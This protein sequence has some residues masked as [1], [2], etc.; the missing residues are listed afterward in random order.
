MD[1]LQKS[2]NN[3]SYNNNNIKKNRT[4][5]SVINIKSKNN[6]HSNFVSLVNNLSSDIKLFY[7]STKLFL[8]QGKEPNNKRNISSKQIF[9]LIEQNL[10]DFISKAKEIFK[11]MKYIQ[12]INLI[13]QDMTHS[14]AS[15]QS[16]IRINPN[17]DNIYLNSN[18]EN[19]FN[20]S[21]IMNK[22]KLFD[23][24][25]YIPSFCEN[26][27]NN[28]NNTNNNNNNYFHKNNSD[29]EINNDNDMIKSLNNSSKDMKI[30]NKYNKYNKLIDIE[31]N[32]NRN[33]VNKIMYNNYNQYNN[34]KR[35]NNNKSV[36]N[37][38]KKI[39]FDKKQDNSS[40]GSLGVSSSKGIN[41]N[42]NTNINNSN[43]LN[44]NKLLIGNN[45]ILD[46]LNNLIA[47]MKELRLIKGNIFIK[48]LDAEKHKNLLNKIYNE[49]IIIIKIISKENNMKTLNNFLE[50]NKQK[51][52]SSNNLNFNNR[53]FNNNKNEN[54]IE[55]IRTDNYNKDINY[56]DLI[57]HQ[58]KQI[59]NINNDNKNFH[60]IKQQ[61][62]ELQKEKEKIIKINNELKQKIIN[63]E[64]IKNKHQ[65]MPKLLTQNF[66]FQFI[67]NEDY[68]GEKAQKILDELNGEIKE[69]NEKIE[70]INIEL[71]NYKEKDNKSNEEISKLNEEINKKK[72]EINKCQKEIENLINKNNE[73]INDNKQLKENLEIENKNIEKYKKIVS[74][75]EE[76]IKDL[77]NNSKINI[78]N[79]N[80]TI[81]EEPEKSNNKLP[82]N[83]S[84]NN[85]NINLDEKKNKKRNSSK[86]NE[87]QMEQDKIYLKYELLKNDYDK[88]NNTLQQ[89]QKL[90]DN[91]SKISSETASKT[92]IDE[93]ILELMAE[94]KKEIEDLK[95][96]YNKNII[97]LKMN[98]PS[99]FSPLTHKILI[100]KRYASYDLKWYLLTILTEEEKNYKNTFWVSDID[101]K[102]ILNQFDKFKTEREIEDE[103]FENLYKMQEKWIKQI[104]E[105]EKL[106]QTLK[107]KL[108]V[109]ENKSITE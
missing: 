84:N 73:Y 55:N 5:S 63:L 71:N 106:I 48:S 54:N 15:P 97:N 45:E 17:N 20:R 4:S 64:K 41:N 59:K 60:I 8:N 85:N 80:S 65:S 94:H 87:Y 2:N 66:Y 76:E 27:N 103:K 37:L 62:I 83:N 10:I 69:K 72:E 52:H 53:L 77:K 24:E 93:Q 75:Q 51:N 82:L 40:I 7:H 109:Y 33:S 90:L 21:Y 74:Y 78:I 3:I 12:K 107:D 104:D 56:R 100:D 98:Q 88:L 58:S 19:N 68:I 89:K 23:E 6:S 25:V 29:N 42:T 67:K 57:I 11:R 81:K 34:L 31:E 18:C 26:N 46:K 91:Y 101:M 99:P 44:Q 96:E 28:N 105:N 16:L 38:R 47:L 39:I 1:I 102:P 35:N 70:K 86:N 9:D 49:I 22:K 61:C 32:P 30:I 92:N 79:N 108:A 95:K 36:I 13:Q 14:G 50:D 43:N